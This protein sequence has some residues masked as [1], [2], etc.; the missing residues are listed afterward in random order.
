MIVAGWVA[1][2]FIF[3]WYVTSLA[4]YESLFGNLASNIIA[5]G[6]LYL[7]SLVLIY[8]LQLDALVRQR[9]GDDSGTP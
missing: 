2:S 6:Y 7:S 4:D 5:M 1:T 3:R 8:G 9:L